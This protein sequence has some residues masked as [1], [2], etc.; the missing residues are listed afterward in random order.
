MAAHKKYDGNERRAFPIS[1]RRHQAA[2]N[3]FEH[4]GLIQRIINIEDKTDDLENEKFL[5]TR[6]FYWIIG[7]LLSILTAVLSFTFYNSLQASQTLRQVQA[8]Q[9]TISMQIQY[10]QKD[11]ET[12]KKKG[13]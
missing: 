2:A 4:S 3:C 9:V 10:L 1:D 11:V 5:S 7:V 13:R 8:A 12:I 6:S